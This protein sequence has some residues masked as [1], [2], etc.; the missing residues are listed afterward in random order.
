MS[1]QQHKEHKRSVEVARGL[2]LEWRGKLGQ[3]LGNEGDV[4]RRL[5]EQGLKDTEALVD[6]VR[7]TT[8]R[9]RSKRSKS[10]A[11]SSV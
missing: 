10:A 4:V 2:L 1:Q 3:A 6:K 8:S 11:V 9:F 7:T 5:L